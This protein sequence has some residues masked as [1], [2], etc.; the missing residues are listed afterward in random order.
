MEMQLA[1]ADNKG[2]FDEPRDFARRVTG[3]RASR[4]APATLS[5]EASGYHL[6]TATERCC[7]L[8]AFLGPIATKKDSKCSHASRVLMN[9]KMFVL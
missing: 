9:S 1:I 6:G 4:S 7:R 2:S 3:L 8:L 5:L